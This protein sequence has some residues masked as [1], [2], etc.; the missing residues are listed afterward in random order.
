MSCELDSHA[1]TTAVGSAFVM[2][3][4]PTRTITVN[5]FSDE[6]KP[7]RDIPITSC[8][9]VWI[10]ND[11]NSYL[12]IFHEALYFGDR[13]SHSLICPNQLRAH[14][15]IVHD[16][17]RQ[18]DPMSPHH[19]EVPDANIIIPLSMHGIIS[20]FHTYKP[21]P[22]DLEDLPRVC[23]TADA[24]WQPYSNVYAEAEQKCIDA[25]GQRTIQKVTTTES[26]SH[27]SWSNSRMIGAVSTYTDSIADGMVL[28]DD[29]DLFHARL[30]ETIHIRPRISSI[31]TSFASAASILDSKT[32]AKRWCIGLTKA[33]KTL[34]VTTQ[35]G[36][37][38]VL[39]PSERKVRKKA[40]W[41]KFPSIK[42]HWYSDEIFSK[43]P[44]VHGDKGASVFTNGKGFDVIYPWRSKK[45]HPEALMSL[46]HEVGVPQIMVSD[47]G[48]ELSHGKSREICSEYRIKQEV[49]V[50]YS[51]WQNAAEASIRELKKSVIRITRK[52]G[53]PRRFWPYAAKW[54]TH[55]RQFTASD[56]PELNGVTP[57]EYVVGTTPDISPLALFDFYQPVY[58]RMPHVDFPYEK[59]LIGRWLGL[60][61]SS[62]D[63]MA[64]YILGA[65]GRIITRKDV[66]ALSQDD[67]A[68]PDIVKQLETFDKSHEIILQ[69]DA[70]EELELPDH[71]LFDEPDD[72]IELAEPGA[73]PL[74]AD[75]YTPEELDEYLTA[76]VMLPH[77]GE[78]VRGTIVGRAKNPDGIPIGQRNSNPML[79]TREYDVKFSDGAT[80]SYTTNM[81]A[82]HLYSQVDTEGNAFNIIKAI[83]NHKS[84]KT[85]VKRPASGPLDKRARHTTRGWKLE[86]ELSDGTTTW[87]DLKDLKNG[88][89]IELAEYATTAGIANEPAFAWWVPIVLRKRR[90]FVKKI[91]TRY[92]KTTHKY[93]IEVPHTVEEALE[94]DRRT[95]TD[96]WRKAIEKEM[97][98]VGMAFEFPA[99]GKVPPG[100]KKI[101][102]HWVFTIKPDLTR[103]A[104]LVAG[105]H[106]TDPPTESTYSSVVSRDS[107]RI[108]FTIAALNG[109]EVLVGDVQNA[110]LNAPTK[111]KT[112]SIAGI[113][114]GPTRVGLPALIV[115][116]LYGLKSSAQRWREHIAQ[117]LRDM[118]YKSSLGD[119]DV[120]MRPMTRPTDGFKYYE[121]VLI[122]IDD[123]LVVSHDPRAVMTRLEQ[124]YTIKPESIGSPTAY[125]GA[126]IKRHTLPRT[127][128]PDNR[129][130]WAMSSD[131]Y[132]K[133]ALGEIE[134]EL[135]KSGQRLLTRVTGPLADGYRPELDSTKELDDARITYYQGLIGILRWIV[136]LGRIDITLPVCL[137][138]S[139]LANPRAGHLEQVLHI[140]AYLKKYNHSSL[141]FDDTRP[142][143]DE[144]RFAAADWSQYYPDA[145]EALPPNMPEPRGNP[146]T[147]T[148]YVDASHA[149]CR[150]TR[151]SHTGVLIFIQK[152]P[153]LWYSKR[154][155]TVESSTFGSEFVAAKIGVEMII[156]LRYKLRM[157]GIPLDGPTYFL[158]DN[159][160][161][162]KNVSK[163]E[164]T[165]KKKHNAVAY[166]LVREAQAAG[167]IR[168]AWEPGETN[169]SD[170]LT[171]PMMGARLRFLSRA[172]LW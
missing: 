164:S 124:T 121:Y 123:I 169:L 111:E 74:E 79:D 140:F 78:H 1:D 18:F 165:L 57:Y 160:S 145:V 150:V 33:D 54:C 61:E 109:L 122:Y 87:F 163:P 162:F 73:A 2:F 154:Q 166:H 4:E 108:A 35:A 125:L 13:L 59:K 153:L 56:I 133:R 126:Q 52:T 9:T 38:N 99:D 17:P 161:L 85:A 84:D 49:T 72:E 159:Q 47:G 89:P 45:H 7:L 63:D 67:L 149:G 11:N 83:I 102:C 136:E 97:K 92:L 167:I 118:G 143:F 60:A 88:S 138:S 71:D 62:T 172:I 142:L 14:G 42:G 36:V 25:T 16:V 28:D 30:E 41:L 104:R 75:D 68:T 37:R 139:Y 96:Y 112:Y 22:A 106:K 141:V 103:K 113:E 144:E 58:Y 44:S 100:Y 81:I 101:P 64:Y 115:R 119:P 8:A 135:A 170:I 76:E 155:N 12:L 148:A 146:V 43:I 86:C 27:K 151:R 157:M 127:D 69:N 24:N 114:F 93:G 90:R 51:Q 55:V 66:W 105:G 158:C 80:E 152:A 134:T 132:V 107:V 70:I 131:P 171:K 156:A 137:M 32:L 5:S 168:M 129:D 128:D 31:K 98:N 48:K 117:T 15:L 65:S 23:M 46:I 147:M 39:V 29:H 94:I 3:T 40:P 116:A 82:E 130:R 91:H 77:G 19:I 110:Y 53:V 10:D 21:T 120:W 6:C 50:P 34:K 95:G 26:T 20:G